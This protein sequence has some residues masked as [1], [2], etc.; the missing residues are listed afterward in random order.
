MRISTEKLF[1]SKLDREMSLYGWVTGIALLF[2][3]T[4]GLSFNISKVH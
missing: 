1:K 2:E 4:L 3:G